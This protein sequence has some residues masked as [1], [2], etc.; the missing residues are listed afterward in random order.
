MGLHVIVY[1]TN[2]VIHV[3]TVIIILTGFIIHENM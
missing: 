3:I 2:T 1:I